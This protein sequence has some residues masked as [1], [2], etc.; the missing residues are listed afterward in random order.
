[1]STSVASNKLLSITS[2]VTLYRSVMRWLLWSEIGGMVGTG[3]SSPFF[4][5]HFL[6]AQKGH[7]LPGCPFH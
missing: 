3:I 1:V 6:F 4:F 7:P 5:S 2:S